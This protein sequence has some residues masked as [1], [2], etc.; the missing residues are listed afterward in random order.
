MTM[1]IRRR[2]SVCRVTGRMDALPAPRNDRGSGKERPMNAYAILAMNEDLETLRKEAAYN[3]A[4]G[5][6]RPSLRKRVSSTF[7]GLRHT[8]RV[9]VENGTLIPK[10]Q[11]YPYRG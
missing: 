4:Y 7:A 11:D 6:Q 8:L 3:K 1:R 5:T 2:M 10:L 9:P